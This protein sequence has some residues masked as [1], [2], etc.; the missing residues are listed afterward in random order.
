MSGLPVI[1]MTGFFNRELFI[2]SLGD[3]SLSKPVSLKKA[4]FMLAG[5]IIWTVP[6]I[7]VFGIYFNPF[8]LVLALGPPLGLAAIGDK[9]LFDGR[10]IVDASKTTLK[11]IFSNKCYTDLTVSDTHTDPE[12]FIEKEVWISR[13]RELMEL[14]ELWEEKSK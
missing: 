11:F 2:Y 10:G 3:I 1:N 7:L 14:A 6:L 5:I 4:S 12:Y 8:F 13:R 9:P